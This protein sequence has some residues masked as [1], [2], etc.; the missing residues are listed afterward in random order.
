MVTGILHWMYAFVQSKQCETA[1]R[2]RKRRQRL[3]SIGR[4]CIAGLP[5]MINTATPVCSEGLSVAG[6]GHCLASLQSAIK[7]MVL[8][9][10]TK[11]GFETD[12]WTVG[13]LHALLVDRLNVDVSEDTVW[14]RCAKRD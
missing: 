11:F 12:L 3:G 14:R 8:A 1:C 4:R 9:P 6:P 2:F 7:K 13:R 5:D 10:A